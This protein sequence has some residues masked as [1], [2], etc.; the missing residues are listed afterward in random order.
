M[1]IVENKRVRKINYFKIKIYP[2]LKFY[3]YL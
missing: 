2:L 1:N 3:F